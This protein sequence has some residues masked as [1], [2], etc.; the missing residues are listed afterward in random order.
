M[1]LIESAS[2]Y[3]SDSDYWKGDGKFIQEH[4]LD[5]EIKDF[6]GKIFAVAKLTC[7]PD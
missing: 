1:Q 6:K 3:R 5:K 7:S 4:I 2:F